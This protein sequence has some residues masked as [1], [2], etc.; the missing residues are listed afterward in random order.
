MK[1]HLS[2]HYFAILMAFSS[3]CSY[4]DV[5]KLSVGSL[6]PIRDEVSSATDI[7]IGKFAKVTVGGAGSMMG[8]M[9][10]GEIAVLGALKGTVS[11]NLDVGF[12]VIRGPRNTE[13][14][15]NNNDTYII[16]LDHREIRKLLPATDDNIA[17]IKQLIAQT[18]K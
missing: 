2:F 1:K 14:E 8:V 18:S 4:A 10:H 12:S 17:N 11:G 3:L 5:N 9:Y 16:I 7:V 13:V 15:P 6:L